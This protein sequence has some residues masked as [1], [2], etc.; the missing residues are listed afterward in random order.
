M[1]LLNS[2]YSLFFDTKSP[3]YPEVTKLICLV[4]LILLILLRK[5]DYPSGAL[6]PR[7]KRLRPCPSCFGSIEVIH[8]EWDNFIDTY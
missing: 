5:T 3:S 1:F 2:R 7:L 8:L 6:Q 4:P